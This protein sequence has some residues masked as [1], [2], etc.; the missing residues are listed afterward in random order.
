[1]KPFFFQ[2]FQFF[3]RD[4]RDGILFFN[5]KFVYTNERLNEQHF[6]MPALCS[7]KLLTLF[8]TTPLKKTD[9]LA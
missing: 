7:F 4:C 1:M 8:N 2:M 5:P 9:A 3:L 6:T